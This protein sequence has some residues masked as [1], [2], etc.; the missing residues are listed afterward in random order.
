MSSLTLEIMIEDARW[1]KIPR[2]RA[3]LEKAAAAA[4]KNL[5]K[6]R[7]LH[8]SVTVLLTSNAK[9]RRFNRDFRG[10][11]KPTNVLSF[12]QF[13]PSKLPKNGKKRDR[14]YMGDVVLGYQYVVAEAKK[15]NKILINHTSHLLIHGILH[16]FG[17]DHV[18]GPEAVSME[19]L[20]AKIMAGLGLPDPYA[21]QTKERK[22]R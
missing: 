12:P 14:I 16:L 9:V 13:E 7:Q 22:A 8:G 2:L 10:L 11:N 3:S 1:R 19:R 15:D 20:E 17:Y 5:P 18:S 6:G 4:F 21:P